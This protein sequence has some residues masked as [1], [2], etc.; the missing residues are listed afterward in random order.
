MKLRLVTAALMVSVS[1]GAPYGTGSV[2]GPTTPSAALAA[3]K[4]FP[5]AAVPRPIV[6]FGIDPHGQA[7]T[8]TSKIAA[9][10]RQLALSVELPAI[11]PDHA[12]ASWPDGSSSTYPATSASDTF[13]ALKRAPGASGSMCAAA[14]PLQVTAV[15]FG[16]AG[17]ETDRGTA[18]MSAWLFKANGAAAEFI[19]PAIPMSALWGGGITNMSTSGGSTV[20]PDGRSLNFGFIGGECDAGY[21]SAIAESTSAVAVAIEAIPKDGS[22]ACSLVGIARS[23]TVKLTNPLGGRVLVDASGNAV[24]VCPDAMRPRC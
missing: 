2:P 9:L 14:T 22:G 13:T 8:N 23:I 11:T 18:Q 12:T 24:G 7:F 5:A 17:F 3:W 1:C 10:C 19:Y 6:L 20:S 4:D 16:V 15:R 21:K